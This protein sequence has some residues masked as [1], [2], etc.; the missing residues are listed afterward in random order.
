MKQYKE[1]ARVLDQELEQ[2]RAFEHSS[3]K[4]RQQ[5]TNEYE[6]KHLKDLY[7]KKLQKSTEDLAKKST[8][9]RDLEVELARSKEGAKSIHEFHSF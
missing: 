6:L 4:Q 7:E 5:S 2:L 1:R 8:L 9:I 3:L